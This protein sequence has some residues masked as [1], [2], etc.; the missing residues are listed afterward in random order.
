[1]IESNDL[2]GVIGQ[3]VPQRETDAPNGVTTQ[4]GGAPADL[5]N[6]D[7]GIGLDLRKNALELKTKLPGALSR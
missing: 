2:N 6:A 3:D 4:T 5:T 7:L 1:V